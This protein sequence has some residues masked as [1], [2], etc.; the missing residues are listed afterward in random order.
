MIKQLDISNFRCYERSTVFI[1]GKSI[2]VGRNNAGKSTMIEALMIISSV[3]RKY[4]TLRFTAPP[5]WVPRERNNGVSIKAYVG[6]GLDIFASTKS[7]GQ[8]WNQLWNW[9]KESSSSRQYSASAGSRSWSCWLTGSWNSRHW[10]TVS[11]HTPWWRFRYGYW[12]FYLH[13]RYISLLK[14]NR[15]INRNSQLKSK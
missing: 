12:F 6:E 3:T 8:H 2:L 7:C 11:G 5:E 1:N 4:K 15:Q 10:S 14:K 13:W 9:R